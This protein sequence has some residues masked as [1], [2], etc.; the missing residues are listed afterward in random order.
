M[1]LPS[2]NILVVYA[3]P[4]GPLTVA[5]NT[6]ATDSWTVPQGATRIV[7]MQVDGVP[8]EP[9]RPQ[10]AARLGMGGQLSVRKPLTGGVV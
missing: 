7:S 6:A 4:H 8:L 3:T 1:G 2:T 9:A 10:M 5:Y